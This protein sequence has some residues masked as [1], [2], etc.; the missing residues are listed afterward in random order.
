MLENQ[1]LT[2]SKEL[3]IIRFITITF[4]LMLLSL[5]QLILQQKKHEFK[6]KRPLKPFN[7]AHLQYLIKRKR[8]IKKSLRSL[9]KISKLGNKNT[10]L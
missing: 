8:L 10:I 9:E 5:R 1:V 3:T 7:K 6:H 4:K 2:R